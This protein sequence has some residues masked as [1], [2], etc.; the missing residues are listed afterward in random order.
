MPHW[1]CAEA[2]PQR[3]LS[4]QRQPTS[5]CTAYHPVLPTSQT[6][7]VSCMTLDRIRTYGLLSRGRAPR[8]SAC[9]ADF[10]PTTDVRH[11]WSHGPDMESPISAYSKSSMI[12]VAALWFAYCATFP[13][14]AFQST[15]FIHRDGISRQE[16]VL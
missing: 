10:S 6:M 5:N 2:G 11:T 3:A 9:P 16:H 4:W 14:P 13:P 12:S 15:W 8:D 1:W 7:S